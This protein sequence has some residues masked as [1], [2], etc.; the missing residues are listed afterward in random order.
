MPAASHAAAI[1]AHPAL[2][3]GIVVA[4]ADLARASEVVADAAPSAAILIAAG[5][6]LADPRVEAPQGSVIP[7]ASA[8]HDRA[9]SEDELARRQERLAELSVRAAS[10]ADAERA[11]RSLADA[12]AAHLD[13]WPSGTLPAAIALVDQL[14]HRAATTRAS[15]DE[16]SAAVTAAEA[17]LAEADRTIEQ[18]RK[19]HT[20]TE[21]RLQRL[22]RLAADAAEVADAAAQAADLRA[23]TETLRHTID[24]ASERLRIATAAREAAEGA[25]TTAERTLDGLHQ[26]MAGLPDPGAGEYA[27]DADTDI[28]SLRATYETAARV[29]DDATRGSDIARELALLEQQRQTLES[30]WTAQR[31]DLRERIEQLAATPAAASPT[32]RTAAE[33]EATDAATRANNLHGDLRTEFGVANAHRK[34]LPDPEPTWAVEPF[35]MPEELEA[36]EQ[37]SAAMDAAFEV[38]RAAAAEIRERLAVA[39]AAKE[40][41]RTT[42]EALNLQTTTLAHNLGDRAPQPA[43]PYEGDAV[44][45]VASALRRI[46]ETSR[47]REE[48]DGR[49]REAAHNAGVF[50]REDRW[51]ELTGELARRLRDDEPL[52]LARASKDLLTQTRILERRLRDDIAHL[53][54]YRQMLVN[55]LGDAVSEA[56]RSLRSARRKSELPSGLG[57]WSHQPFLKIGI[58]LAKDRAELDGRLRRFTNDL[59]ERASSGAN[60]PLGADL[61]CQ[62]TL[63]CTDKAVTVDILK[64]N[65]AQ[66]LRYVPITETATL[67]GGMR[68]TAA[69]AMFCTLAR[70]RAANR[71]GRIGVGTLILDNP[72][73]DANATYL[74]ALQRLVAQMSDVQLVYTTGVND[75][76]ALRLFPVVTRLT[77]EAAKRSHLAYV[78]ADEA[79]LKRLAP[80][81]GD[82][83]SP[84]PV[85]SAG[86]SPSSPLISPIWAATRTT[87]N[88][89][90][91]R[92]A[93]R[94]A[95]C[96]CRPPSAAAR[97]GVRRRPSRGR[98][99]AA[100]RSEPAP[101][102]P[103]TTHR[104]RTRQRHHV[105]RRAGSLRPPRAAGLHHAGRQT[106]WR[107]T[108]DDPPAR[109]LAT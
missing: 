89:S 84:G 8:L 32:S 57:D 79:F 15:A 64:P 72:L 27:D 66:R 104:S 49:W 101:A 35:D 97:C 85:S 76:D 46:A 105:V 109:L 74:V 91:R 22:E 11:A 96:R 13:E 23:E 54:T 24:D 26:Q 41:C 40:D 1:A 42:H 48:A 92:T 86:S 108:G 20:Q 43:S 63:S 53:D 12:I 65:K 36:L 61:I 31:A 107:A 102:P 100:I 4:T 45:A 99:T 62:A 73:G 44:E 6:L 80:A 39:A 17:L 94:G 30:E 77:N 34:A 75:L 38:A 90:A 18:H 5:T 29:Y 3:D 71:T 58:E 81:D 55:S 9:A 19:R 33:K 95:S 2:V 28:V 88:G 103:R 87:N 21:L 59:L 60:L 98:T 83:A 106:R 37:M 51:A 14:G 16:A 52:E 69:I 25:K 68:A 70:I 10:I 50:A 67:S 47:K 93:R 82:N 56:A 7:P 78:V